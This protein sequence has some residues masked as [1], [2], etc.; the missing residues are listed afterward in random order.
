MSRSN[1]LSGKDYPQFPNTHKHTEKPLLLIVSMPIP[2]KINKFCPEEQIYTKAKRN[3][4]FPYLPVKHY[5]PYQPPLSHVWQS[6]YCLPQ[7][8]NSRKLSSEF[9]IPTKHP[10]KWCLELE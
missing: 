2:V 5:C 3:P 4:T 6:N 1:P 7:R 10:L 8:S 9:E